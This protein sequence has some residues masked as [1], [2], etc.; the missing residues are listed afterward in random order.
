MRAANKMFLMLGSAAAVLAAAVATAQQQPVG[1]SVFTA[2][3]VTI[4]NAAFQTTCARCHQ[5]D[6][7]GSNEAPP[8][9]GTNFIAALTLQGNIQNYV[10]VTGA[11]LLKPDPADWLMV[12][13][14][15]P[16]WSHSGLKQITKDNVG[17]LRLAWVWAMNDQV[18]ANEPTPLVHNGIMYLVNVHNIVQPLDAKTGELLWENRIRPSGAVAGGTGAMRNLAIYQDKGYG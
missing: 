2:E 11:M 14:S 8:L 18:G 12:R 10:P 4:G 13:G 15:Y 3:Q 1:N 9:F 16:G 7:R 17:T 5:A 6:L